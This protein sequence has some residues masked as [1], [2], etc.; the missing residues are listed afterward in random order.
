MGGLKWVILV[1]EKGWSGFYVNT[2]WIGLGWVEMDS[3]VEPD[4]EIK[5]SRSQYKILSKLT[6]IYWR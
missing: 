2:G 5:T 4:P 3:C 1:N 6:E